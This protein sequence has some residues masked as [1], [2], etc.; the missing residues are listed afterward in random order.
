MYIGTMYIGS[1]ETVALVVFL[2]AG[3]ASVVLYDRVL[4]LQYQQDRIGW[5]RE[6]RPPGFLWSPPEASK[7]RPVQLATIGIR[8]LFKAPP[9]ARPPTP[10]RTVYQLFRSA[11]IVA[12]V[13]FGVLGLRIFFAMF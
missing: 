11:T 10:A 6:G 8:W 4:L 3:L 2:A 9:I 5:V 13:A 7:P 12:L 1:T